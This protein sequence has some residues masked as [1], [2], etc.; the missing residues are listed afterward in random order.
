MIRRA[1]SLGSRRFSSVSPA[2]R[3]EELFQSTGPLPHAYR[4]LT[5]D[6]VSTFEVQGKQVRIF[7]WPHAPSAG[8]PPAATALP[9][10]PT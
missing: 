9:P 1:V 5:S 2:F 8:R 6:Y 7:R 10:P 4:K 3:Y